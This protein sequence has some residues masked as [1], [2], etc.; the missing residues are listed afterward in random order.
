MSSWSFPADKV[1]IVSRHALVT[2]SAHA[3]TQTLKTERGAERQSVW[4][5]Y[6]SSLSN[7]RL[8]L[9]ENKDIL[10]GPFG[11]RV[12]F[13]VQQCFFLYVCVR[14]REKKKAA[15]SGLQWEQPHHGSSGKVSRPRTG[16]PSAGTDHS[17]PVSL[18]TDTTS[19]RVPNNIAE[20]NQ[21][22]GRQRD[23]RRKGGKRGGQPS[24]AAPHLADPLFPT[25]KR[26]G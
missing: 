11:S 3:I 7:A 17:T 22:K 2:I 15:W 20:Q 24:P 21:K 10:S 16:Q 9:R 25:R 12:H 23:I 13:Y 1:H 6:S 8:P 18:S 19:L 14:E 5:H 4:E 26:N